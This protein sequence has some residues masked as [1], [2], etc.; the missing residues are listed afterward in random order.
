MLFGARRYVVVL[1]RIPVYRIPVYRIPANP[2]IS[3]EVS[4]DRQTNAEN[5]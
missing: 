1:Y 2:G 5:H 3:E 4:N